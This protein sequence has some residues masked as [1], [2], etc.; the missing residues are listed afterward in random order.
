MSINTLSGKVIRKMILRFGTN[1]LLLSIH[2]ECSKKDLLPRNFVK[3]ILK[4][5][6]TERE[7]HHLLENLRHQKLNGKEKAVHRKVEQ[8]E[9]RLQAK[10][11]M[12]CNFQNSTITKRMHLLSWE[13]NPGQAVL[14][15]L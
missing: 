2:P 3:V 10:D 13:R 15:F 11:V 1:S 4:H 6:K 9:I 7:M 5:H 14:S 12:Q 8:N